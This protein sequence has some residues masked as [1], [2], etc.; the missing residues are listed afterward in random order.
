M[1]CWEHCPQIPYSQ[2]LGKK[3]NIGTYGNS[4]LLKNISNTLHSLV[5]FLSLVPST[6]VEFIWKLEHQNQP[7]NIA[8]HSDNWPR[9]AELESYVKAVNFKVF[10]FFLLSKLSNSWH[11]TPNYTK[12]STNKFIHIYFIFKNDSLLAEDT[13]HKYTHISQQEWRV[14][15]TA[16][17][18]AISLLHGL[19]SIPRIVDLNL[20]FK[21]QRFLQCLSTWSQ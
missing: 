3:K 16:W 11:T 19:L 4:K 20:L 13:G 21:G 10:F 6:Q 7:T 1:M 12:Y 9:L 5:I 14:S 2:L 15:L 18:V 8:Q 17:I